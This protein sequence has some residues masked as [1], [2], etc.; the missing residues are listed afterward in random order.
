M[1]SVMIIAIAFVFFIP[2]HESV[3]AYTN[4]HKVSVRSQ[5]VEFGPAK[6]RIDYEVI[7]DI[8]R[9]SN[10]D[11]GE[12]FTILVQ[13]RDGTVTYTVEVFGNTYS[14][15][16]NL[17]LGDEIVINLV[18]GIDGYVSTSALSDVVILGPVSNSQQTLDWQYS[19]SQL[20]RSS[21]N[22]NTH[23]FDEVIVKI[24]IKIGIDA[25]L[26]LNL[27]GV[28]NEN[29]VEKNLGTLDA[30]PIIEEHISI[31]RP[32]TVI[33]NLENNF[34]LIFVIIPIIISVIV[35]ITIIAI[36]LKKKNNKDKSKKEP[37]TNDI[38]QSK[39]VKENK[40]TEKKSNSIQKII[41]I[42]PKSSWAYSL[43]L[44]KGDKLNGHVSGTSNFLLYLTDRSHFKKF[45]EKNTSDALE[46]YESEC[47]ESSYDFSY[48]I[49]HGGEFLLV[50]INEK[51]STISVT[52]DY[53]VVKN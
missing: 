39:P 37:I 20:I 22:S 30:Y 18:T 38:L 52:L 29:I 15:P 53:F 47:D 9:P 5:E 24:P 3:D 1:K 46:F 31:N 23:D 11:P 51:K 34:E 8:D 28:F 36:I 32:G 16:Q 13:P 27:L 44:E 19:S 21:V 25:G 17:R 42:D 4:Q 2:F 48:H 40:T 12:S 33:V 49:P 7:V 41:N 50:M 43:Q 45:Q 35:I 10:V 26:K 14:V 6:I